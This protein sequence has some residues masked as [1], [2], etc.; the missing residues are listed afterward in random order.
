VLVTAIF[1]PWCRA[2]TASST[3]ALP[4]NALNRG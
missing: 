1:P 3:I 4:M 2:K